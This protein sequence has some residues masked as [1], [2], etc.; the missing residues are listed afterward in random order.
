ML[1]DVFDVSKHVISYIQML[2][3]CVFSWIN[4]SQTFH[5][6]FSK[7]FEIC[8]ILVLVNLNFSISAYS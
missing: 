4:K 1:F 7:I 2:L 6:I 3:S 8:Y 5:L